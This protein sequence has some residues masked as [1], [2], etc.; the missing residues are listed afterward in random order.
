MN[1]NKRPYVIVITGGIATG[2]SAVS[3][4]ITKLGFTL[5]DSDKIVHDGYLLKGELY[6]SLIIEFG[7]AILDKNNFIDRQILGKIALNDN[8]SM[9]KLNSI[10]HKYVVNELI[11]GINNS[12]EDTIF[13]DIPLMFEEKETL[14]KL[15]LMYDEIWLVYVSEDTQRKRLVNRANLEHKNINQTLKILDMQIP[16]DMKKNLADIVI[17]NEGTLEELHKSIDKLLNL[18]LTNN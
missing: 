12:N 4:Y 1:Q 10:V 11:Y 2:K 5:L 18:K 7:H 8:A 15:G 13:L 3:S 6:H 16:I 9:I 14:I 17:Q